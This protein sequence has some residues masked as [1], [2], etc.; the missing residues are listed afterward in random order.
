MRKVKVFLGGYINYTNAQNLNC[1]AIAEHLDKDKFEVY[2]LK[3]SFGDFQKYNVYTF[4]CYKPFSIT[5]HIGFLWG[6]LN[7]DIAY[8]PKH[9]DTPLWVLRFAKFLNRSIFTTIEGNVSDRSKEN[10]IDLFPNEDLFKIH[11]SY[12]DKIFPIT[13][14]LSHQSN[15]LI[16]IGADILPLGVYSNFFQPS[17]K[18]SKLKQ[19]V[20]VGGIIKRK[21]VDEFIK[22]ANIFPD[23]S[24]TII[25]E[26]EQ[27][28]ELESKS[29]LNVK[30][31]GKLNHKEIKYVFKE[32]ELL[33]LPSRSEGFP[34]VILEA[35][36]SGVPS[37]V[38]AD[39]GANNWIRNRYNGFVVDDFND[40]IS[41]VNEL[42]K[43]D[44]LLKEVSKNVIDLGSQFN[45]KVVI[46]DWEKVLIDLNNGE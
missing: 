46:K 28:K 11:F 10:L 42:L 21:K 40:V 35:G 29:P 2:T 30:F 6:I 17:I 38:Y 25:G 36:A 13:K 9:I 23:L 4:N 12:F 7:C 44:K 22:L 33:F 18:E 24:F 27:R 43:N 1:K 14:H 31:L 20:F 32:S 26:G 34:K 5:K 16:N 19:V 37:I 15:S 39:Y 8:L 41:I 45:W 3:V